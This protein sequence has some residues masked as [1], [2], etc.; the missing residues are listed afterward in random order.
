MLNHFICQRWAPRCKEEKKY[1]LMA[2]WSRFYPNTYLV[3]G[4]EYPSHLSQKRQTEEFPSFS[5]LSSDGTTSWYLKGN[6]G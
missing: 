2:T 1:S 4:N 3:F 6:Y 5:S